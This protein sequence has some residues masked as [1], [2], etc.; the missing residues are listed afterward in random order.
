M[1]APKNISRRNFLGQASCAAVGSSALFSTLFNLRMASVAAAQSTPSSSEDYKALVCIFLGGGNDSFNMLVPRSGTAYS[2]YRTTRS[3]LALST[4]NLLALNVGNTDGRDFGIHNAMPEVQSLFNTGKSAMVCNVGTLVEPT[5][6]ASLNSGSARLPLGL[7]S[8]SDQIMQWQTSVPDQRSTSG[9]GGRIADLLESANSDQTVSMNISMSGN[10][11]FQTGAQVSSFVAGSD[12]EGQEEESGLYDSL[13]PNPYQELL[14]TTVQ[15]MI[16][17]EY[18]HLFE[19][20]YASA[21]N[22][23]IGGRLAY[24]R[25]LQ[26]VSEFQTQF[27]TNGIGGAMRTVAKTIAARQALGKRRQTFFI[28]FGGWDHHDEVIN[29]QNQ[30][31]AVVSQGIHALNSAMEEIGIA[32]KVTSFTASDF[33][34]TL[35]SNGRGS[36]HAWGGN[37]IVTGGAVSGGLLYGNYPELYIGNNLDT[38]RGRLIPTTST[39]EYFAELALWFGVS[40][41]ELPNLFPNLNRFYNLNSG[42]APLGFMKS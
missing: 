37:Q 2:D 5:T 34:R 30:M 8:H 11:T 41:S 14:S 7:Y 31:L 38:G 23:S 3:D 9:W 42:S 12:A 19:R 16:D 24:K 15:N 25:A 39:D 10:N 27:P 40:R 4:S 22:S 21:V 29:A 18:V 20:N 32:D 6:L 17:Q 35:T 33:G 26:S 36:D 1:C 13:N 28:M